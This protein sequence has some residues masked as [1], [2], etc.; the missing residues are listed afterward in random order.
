MA[1]R[2][3]DFSQLLQVNPTL[4][5]IY[6]PLTAGR[7]P[8]RPANVIRQ[9]F[10]GNILPK[11]RII[12][13]AY[14]SYAGFMPVPNND[15]VNPSDEPAN[16][17]NI[18]NG[19]RII[20]H[21]DLA[22][23]I[24]FNLS[25][26]HRFFGRWAYSDFLEDEDDWTYSTVRGLQS[27]D[28]SRRTKG[29]TVDYVYTHSAATRRQGSKASFRRCSSPDT[30][31][32]REAAILLAT[33]IGQRLSEPICRTYKG[34]IRFAADSVRGNTCGQVTWAELPRACFSSLILSPAG[35]MTRLHRRGTW[36]T[37]GPRS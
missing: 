13:P 8:A 30:P 20:D 33:S 32:S 23:R 5:Q 14:S 6:D 3:G 35:T 22:N 9:P 4:Y 11:S 17:L 26:K 24:D 1:N 27:A 31:D 18:A 16:N 37:V 12:N 36:G 25:S 19:P 7:D 15:P 2:E 10:A 34:G 28:L 21:I 29:A